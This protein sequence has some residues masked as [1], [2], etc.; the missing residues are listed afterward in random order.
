MFMKV[1]AEKWLGDG[2]YTVMQHIT[3]C[4]CRGPV[5]ELES[6]RRKEKIMIISRSYM[7][8][9]CGILVGTSSN[10]YTTPTIHHYSRNDFKFQDFNH[11]PFLT[12]ICITYLTITETII[13][14]KF[15][16]SD[17]DIANDICTSVFL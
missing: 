13:I 10:Q 1:S 12:Y 6:R 9:W 14:F 17:G 2:K 7:I 16:L 8:F 4:Y 5:S 3:F 11:Y 15:L